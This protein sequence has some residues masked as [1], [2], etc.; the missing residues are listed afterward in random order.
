MTIA[1]SLL[2]RSPLLY[3]LEM[4][5]RGAVSRLTRR[6]VVAR[7]LAGSAFPRLQ[8]G[9][10]QHVMDGWLNTDR[11]IYR[12]GAIVY[13][14]ARRPLPL[15]TAAFA[16]AY[17]EHQIEHITAADAAAMLG[18]CFR[19]LRPGG[20]IRIATPDLEWVGSL[21][22]PE[23]TADRARYVAWMSRQLGLA[24]PD[25]A[26]V[27]REMF[28]GVEGVPGAGHQRLYSFDSLRAELERAGFRDVTRCV[29]QESDDPHLAGIEGHGAAVNN[30]EIARLE[31]LIVEAVRP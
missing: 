31:S 28:S 18:E 4:W 15:P 10:G 27:M 16:Y 26:A 24:G 12:R 25:A 11:R 2:A 8:I 30:E 14:D 9:T 29:M 20:R 7:Y 22:T 21:A 3:R 6:R 17:T 1:R 23:L 13:V 5:R 19:V